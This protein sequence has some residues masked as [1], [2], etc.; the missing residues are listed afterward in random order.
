MSLAA[1]VLMMLLP[2]AAGGIGFVAWRRRRE[3]DQRRSRELQMREVALAIRE[4][5]HHSHTEVE[6][7]CLAR[8]SGQVLA[9]IDSAPQARFRYSHI[10]EIGLRNHL[11]KTLGVDLARVYWRFTIDCIAEIAAASEKASPPS[12]GEI[13]DAASRTRPREGEDQAMAEDSYLNARALQQKM[14]KEYEVETGTWEQFEAA[15]G[16]LS[17]A[18]NSEV[19]P[20]APS[21]AKPA[22]ENR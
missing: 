3:R 16:R 14:G 17:R 12:V 19:A 2:A 5:F 15:G 7:E 13:L 20:V 18:V 1:L 11:Q 9:L 8:G 6:V 4:Y 10:I 22:K 21:K